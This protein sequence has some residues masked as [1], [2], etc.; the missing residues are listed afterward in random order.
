MLAI[1]ASKLGWDPVCG[2]DHEQPAVEAST[3][4][5]KANGVELELERMNLRE[6]LPDL[7]PTV[8]A[9]MTSPILKAVAVQL[10][11]APAALVCSGIL[12]AEL[13][14]VAMAFAPAGLVETDRRQQGDWAALLFR[15]P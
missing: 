4:N 6:R 14:D 2:Y 7:A 10:T 9:N 3:V 13:D 8:V 15:R 5:A 1:A 11:S 12:P